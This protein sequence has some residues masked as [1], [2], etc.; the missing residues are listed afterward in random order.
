M[1]IITLAYWI[2]NIFSTKGIHAF[3]RKLIGK[4]DVKHQKIA[5][6]LMFLAIALLGYWIM[7]L[8]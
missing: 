1:I 8:M 2:D 5:L 7:G 4:C 6:V 3:G